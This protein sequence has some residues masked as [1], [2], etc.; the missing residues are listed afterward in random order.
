[1]NYW[2]TYEN[3]NRWSS[4]WFTENEA[5]NGI[6]NIPISFNSDKN[7]FKKVS[8][9]CKLNP[10]HDERKRQDTLK[11]CLVV[12]LKQYRPKELSPKLARLYLEKYEKWREKIL[13]KS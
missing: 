4:G 7:F 2:F 5:I 1:M 3:F 12:M 13:K 9:F 10:I 6:E 11:A 8:D